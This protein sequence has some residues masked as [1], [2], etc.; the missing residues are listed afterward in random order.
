MPGHFSLLLAREGLVAVRRPTLGVGLGGQC[1]CTMEREFFID[2]LTDRIHFIM[3]MNF[4]DRPGA[5]G[6]STPFFKVALYLPSSRTM[7]ILPPLL[8]PRKVD[9]RQ[10]G[11]GNSNSHGARTVHHK[12]R[13]IRTSRLARKNSLSTGPGELPPPCQPPAM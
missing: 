9:I 13:W 12:H 6:V 7:D 11:K 8:I 2:N 4:M 5:M 3:E 10:P 1:S